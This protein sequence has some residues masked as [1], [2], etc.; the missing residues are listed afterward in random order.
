MIRMTSLL[1][2]AGLCAWT[3]LAPASAAAATGVPEQAAD[4]TERDFHFADGT[5]LPDIRIQRK[6]AQASG[7]LADEAELL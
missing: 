3:A 2:A 5:T 7:R 1:A 4:F 6:Q